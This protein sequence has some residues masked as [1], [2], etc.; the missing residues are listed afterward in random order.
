MQDEILYSIALKSCPLVGD[1]NFNKLVNAVGSAKEVW[2]ISKSNLYG[3]SG[4]GRKIAEEIGNE[5]HLKFAETELDFCIKN[6]I[7]IKLKHLNQLPKLLNECYDAPSILY[8]KGIF[9]EAKIPISIVGT[10]NMTSY[11]KNFIKE[12][13][14]NL[15]NEN[16]NIISGLALGVDGHAHREALNKNI[17]TSAVLAHGFGTIYPSEHAKLAEEI[18]DKG[19]ALFTE[20][21]SKEKPHRENF[22]QRNRIIAGISPYTI[23]VETAYAGG[24]IS[25]ANFANQYNREVFALPGRISDKYSQGCNL[26]I[27]K[28][29]AKT[30]SSIKELKS[31]LGLEKEKL[32]TP[33]LF[34]EKKVE[35][36]EDLK[37]IYKHISENNPITLDDLSSNCGVPTHQLLPLLLELELANCIKTLSG[38][39]YTTK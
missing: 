39:N 38:R 7:Q 12:L 33:S 18:L 17:A 3:I 25:T 8:Q 6:N 9:D 26:L 32:K 24:S 37:P 31:E 2:N 35:L 21:P 16:T 19:G 15:Q 20:F 36:R 1:V 14:E 22:I 5:K 13:C 23:V 28:N 34:D 27:Y 29:Q 4:I 30:I 10:R 11:G